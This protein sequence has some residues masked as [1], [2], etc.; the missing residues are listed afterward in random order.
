MITC[1]F[2]LDDTLYMEIEFLYSG[3]VFVEETISRSFGI[4]FSGKLMAAHKRGVQDIWAW[5]CNELNIETRCKEDF[6]WLY[7]NHQPTISLPE[8]IKEMLKELDQ[9][10]IMIGVLTDG[11]CITQRNKV[12]ALGLQDYKLFISSEYGSQKPE[13]LRFETIQKTWGPGRYFYVGDNPSKDFIAPNQLGWTTVGAYWFQK[14]IHNLH[15]CVTRDAQPD[16]IVSCPR[17][18]KSILLRES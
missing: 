7:R 12:N 10:G 2:D 18:M 4:D 5:A 14:R 16:I 9:H 3:I 6:L 17:K 8:D 1:I 13:K 15:E 11:R